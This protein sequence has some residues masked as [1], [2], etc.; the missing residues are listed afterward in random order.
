V[1]AV[2]PAGNDSHALQAVKIVRE[3]SAAHQ[4]CA[5]VQCKIL[6]I[7]Y[8]DVFEVQKNA[9][10]EFS[11]LGPRRGFWKWNAPDQRPKEESLKWSERGKP[12]QYQGAEPEAWYWLTDRLLKIDESEKTVQVF[13]IPQGTVKFGIFD[14]S[15]FLKTVDSPLLFVPGMPNKQRLE[16]L[17]QGCLFEVLRENETH[18]WIAG[19]PQTKKLAARFSQFQLYLKKSPWSLKAAKVVHPGGHQESVYIFSE[20]SFDPQEWDEP[21][22]TGYQQSGLMPREPVEWPVEARRPEQPGL[23]P[24]LLLNPVFTLG[25]ALWELIF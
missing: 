24:T 13:P 25:F 9:A 14:I 8:D 23:D 1:E 2:K 16:S 3:W 6:H 4:N 5:A 20:V 15:D 11:Y 10:G 18:V 12:Y 17:I 7:W 19:A 22:L 21:D